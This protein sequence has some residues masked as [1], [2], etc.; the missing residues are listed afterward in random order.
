[1]NLNSKQI[2][3]LVGVYL[4]V[5]AFWSLPFFAK[6]DIWARITA[7]FSGWELVYFALPLLFPVI[8]YVLSNS[9]TRVLKAR[10]SMPQILIVAVAVI[11]GAFGAWMWNESNLTAVA[12][13]FAAVLATIGWILHYFNAHDLQRKQH[14]LDL[15]IQFRQN[16]VFQEHE[17]NIFAHYP[18]GQKVPATDLERLHSDLKNKANFRRNEHGIYTPPVLQ[19]IRFVANYYEHISAAVRYGNLDQAMLRETIQ[20]IM[21]GYRSKIDSYI[22]EMQKKDREFYEHFTWLVNQWDDED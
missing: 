21:S 22:Q 1:M 16:E 11:G 12:I 14:T 2:K 18:M 19:S 10:R 4:V 7:T 5:L 20:D 9:I 17:R 15:V 6:P 3:V 13:T 8:L